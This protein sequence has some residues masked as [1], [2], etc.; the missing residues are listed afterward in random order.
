M[1]PKEALVILKALAD[2]VDPFTGEIYPPES[3]YQK[4]ETVRA[5]F[6]AIRELE[7]KKTRKQK[8]TRLA[9]DETPLNKSGAP[10]TE[11]EDEALKAAFLSQSTVAELS[12]AHQRTEGGIRSRLVRLRLIEERSDA[13]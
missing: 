5:L 6:V 2:G 7:A 4:A 1:E 10:W 11:E 12:E 8:V 9:P 13:K 3:P